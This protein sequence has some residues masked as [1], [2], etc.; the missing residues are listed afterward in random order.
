VPLDGI[1]SLIDT[2]VD[3]GKLHN[4]MLLALLF[5]RHYRENTAQIHAS[6]RSFDWHGD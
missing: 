5:A 4:P 2:M 1:N 3:P 6:R